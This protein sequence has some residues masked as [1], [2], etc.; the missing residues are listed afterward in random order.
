M[1]DHTGEIFEMGSKRAKKVYDYE[2]STEDKEGGVQEVKGSFKDLKGELIFEEKALIK[3]SELIKDEIDQRQLKQKA[4]IE[5]AGNEVVFTL[6]DSD[7][8]T[9]TSKEKVKGSLVVPATFTA[10]VRENWD[11]LVKGET[12][13]FRFAV[14]DRLETVGFE[15]TKVSEETVNEKKTF[16]F[17]MKA[18]SFI[19]AALVDP[20]LFTYSDKG[21]R[22]LSYVGRVAPKIPKAK[23]GWGDLDA[24][25]VY[26]Y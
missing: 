17:K 4:T 15:M 18:S 10:W 14:W 25:I 16:T 7:G 13:E 24:E 9:K 2:H 12:V 26:K 8:K 6:T 21:E 1:V 5:K 11:R 19:I 23:G 20:I 22:L 3:G